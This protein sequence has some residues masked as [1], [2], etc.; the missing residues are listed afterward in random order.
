MDGGK[1]KIKEGKM[2]IF[3]KHNILKKIQEVEGPT[4]K[5]ILWVDDRIYGSGGW[6]RYYVN[7]VHSGR[8]TYE[9]FEKYEVVFS[10]HHASQKGVCRAMNAGFRIFE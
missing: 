4:Y 5:K 10:E 9:S 1:I 3:G 2:I 8:K 6:H 7:W